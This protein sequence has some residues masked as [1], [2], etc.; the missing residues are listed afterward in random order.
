MS[1]DCRR[2]FVLS[3]AQRLFSP[4]RLSNGGHPSDI[5]KFTFGLLLFFI[6]ITANP[7][8]SSERFAYQQANH[9]GIGHT[10]L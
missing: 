5:T 9:R 10:L 1:L 3:G 2:R 4:H 6:C 8:R 7:N